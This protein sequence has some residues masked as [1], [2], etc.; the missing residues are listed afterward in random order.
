MNAI[1]YA[2]DFYGDAFIRDPIPHYAD[3]REA[4][5]VLWLE[6]NNAYAVARDSE[7]RDVL[8]RPDVFVS[9]KG[10]SLN[11]D[12]NALLVGST[13]N[14]DP[15][16]QKFLASPSSAAAASLLLLFLDR[17]RPFCGW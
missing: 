13:L 11:D 10:L 14:S 1:H 15:S 5:P 3:M 6:Q 9:G 12:V 17:S 8:R 2:P 16:A 7:V 4:G